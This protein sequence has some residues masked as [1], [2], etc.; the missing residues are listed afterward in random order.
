MDNLLELAKEIVLEYGY[1]GIFLIAFTES[2][3]QPVPPDPFISGGT[4][5]GLNPLNASLVATV[6]SVLG[7]VVGYFL[8]KILGEPVFKKIFKEKWYEKGEI[9]FRKYGVFAV[10]VAGLTPI[11]F[12]V[13]CWL[14]GIFEMP[15]GGFVIASFLGRFP[16]FL[17]IAFF[18]KWVSSF[19][20]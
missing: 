15:L 17:F 3:I 18:S 9:L 12:K 7:A 4:V 5:F 13:V 1:L 8:G 19:F 10:I 16:R 11:P 6:G 14:A 20:S 2:I